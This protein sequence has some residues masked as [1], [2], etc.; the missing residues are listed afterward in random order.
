MRSSLL[1]PPAKTP[2]LSLCRQQSRCAMRPYNAV[3][4]Y[5]GSR[6]KNFHSVGRALFESH[7]LTVRPFFPEFQKFQS[8]EFLEL[9]RL[10]DFRVKLAANLPPKLQA[11]AET[12]RSLQIVNSQETKLPNLRI[13]FQNKRTV[14]L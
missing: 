8:I 7:I 1:Y 3:D 9:I 6:L 10:P 4:A 14:S 11:A 2:D 12:R 5:P 13:S